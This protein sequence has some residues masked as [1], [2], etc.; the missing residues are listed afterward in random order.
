MKQ[1]VLKVINV[2]Q[3]QCLPVEILFMKPYRHTSLGLERSQLRSSL[4][5]ISNMF[6]LFY[7]VRMDGSL[8]YSIRTRNDTLLTMI[9]FVSTHTNDTKP[10]THCGPVTPY[11]VVS[12][13]VVSCHMSYILYH[14]IPYLISNIISNSIHHIIYHIICN[15]TYIISCHILYHI[16]S[17][18]VSCLKDCLFKM[19]FFSDLLWKCT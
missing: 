17:Y 19:L 4:I 6:E 9:N 3:A 1:V 2:L 8:S 15:I 13:H 11:S 5:V 14:I 16:I 12:C 7:G 18:H 10:T